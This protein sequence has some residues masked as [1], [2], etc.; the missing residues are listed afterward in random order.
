MTGEN[1][2]SQ[3]AAEQFG[4]Q[5][6]HYAVSTGVHAHS[7]GL[8]VLQEYASLGGRGVAVDIATGAGF[9]AFA[10]SPYVER[11]LATDIAAGMLRQTRQLA[12]ERNLGNV[13][14]AF[15]EAE[16]MPFAGG[17]LDMVTCRQAA[18][19]FYKLPLA[20]REIS[21]VL[22]PG[23]VFLLS[24]T[25]AP[26]ED[27][28]A[29]WMNDVEL[30]RDT[31]HVWD[32]KQS[33]W[34]VMLQEVGLAVTHLQMARVHLEFN[35]WVKRSATPEEEVDSLRRDFLSASEA[36]VDA[37]GIEPEGG[38]INFSWPVVVLRAVKAP[39]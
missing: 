4:R 27:A 19:H 1:G 15:V 20:L 38:G 3:S 12:G 17:S 32:R 39:I 18:H 36:V 31:T 14:L 37:F 30:R 9:T 33:E 24:D 11:V 34:R 5:A 8:D 6:E 29:A 16:H 21:R 2:S 22:K 23:G 26:E 35:D 25:C 28:V 7:E 13:E 10:V